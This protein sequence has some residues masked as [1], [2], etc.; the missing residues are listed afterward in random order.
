MQRII[1][2][3]I[4]SGI[5]S[6]TAILLMLPATAT[7]QPNHWATSPLAA[8]AA[9]PARQSFEVLQDMVQHF[10]DDLG[11]LREQNETVSPAELARQADAENVYPVST[12]GDYGEAHRRRHALRPHQAGCGRGGRN[13]QMQQMQSLARPMRQRVRGPPR[14]PDRHERPRR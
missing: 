2:A 4:L 10:A 14:R 12:L 5:V 8:K 13:L 1:V 7:V 11:R 9:E 3:A 6:A